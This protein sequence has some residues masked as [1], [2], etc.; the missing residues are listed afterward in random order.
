[1]NKV[2]NH[3]YFNELKKIILGEIKPWIYGPC[4]NSNFPAD[5]SLTC[6]QIP[7]FQSHVTF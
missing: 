6:D 7:G 5:F 4:K 2:F 1:M 3:L